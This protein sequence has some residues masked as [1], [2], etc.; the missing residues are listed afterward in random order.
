[1]KIKRLLMP[2]VLCIALAACAT[3]RETAPVADYH[4]H[5]LS[6]AGAAVLATQGVTLDPIDAAK[7]VAELDKAGV[8]RAV[9]LSDAFFFDSPAMAS[10]HGSYAAVMAEN[11]WTARE[12]S[13]FPDRLVAF[14][15]VSPLSE[16]AL[17]EINRCSRI[18]AFKGLKLHL[19]E[20]GVN[21]LDARHVERMRAVFQTANKLGFPILTHIG[22]AS[23][24]P[25]GPGHARVFVEELL[26][27]A[28]DVS[29]IVGH[30]WGGGAYSDEILKVFTDAAAQHPNLY[31]EISG[32]ALRVEPDAAQ[33]IA[34]RMREAG[35]GRFLFGSDY[36]VLNGLAYE[37]VWRTYQN[38]M[39]LTS[40][41]F[42][43]I[44][45]N[46]APFLR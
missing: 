5:L 7:A 27:L 15:S 9:I 35:M 40:D 3:V 46:V 21:L 33:Q 38:N 30:L 10:K 2:A 24:P 41:E 14:C 36:P 44:A 19:D 20:S 11:D 26:P 23:T 31:F 18:A 32:D 16:H 29:V 25:Y 28:P 39:P 37:Q 45:G 42:R 8:R 17:E 6:P 4:F 13:R 43:R 34:Q 1:M 12:V 22:T